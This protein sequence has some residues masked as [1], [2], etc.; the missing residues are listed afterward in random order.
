MAH[1][2][3]HKPKPSWKVEDSKSYRSNLSRN[4]SIQLVRIHRSAM[5]IL[6][7]VL[8]GLPLKHEDK[9]D[10][11]YAKVLASDCIGEIQLRNKELEAQCKS[12]NASLKNS[13]K[14]PRTR[15]R[16]T[17]ETSK[18]SKTASKS[19][20]SR[21]QSSSTKKA[22][23]SQATAQPKRRKNSAGKK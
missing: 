12:L 4:N 18:Q 19:S 20:G 23:S 8:A 15:G 9:Q 1:R 16:T 7:D 2:A 5:V 14:T 13:S 6:D 10:I 3:K 17:K 22:T 11:E 21:S